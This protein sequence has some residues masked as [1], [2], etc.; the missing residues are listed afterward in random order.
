V[1]CLLKE[2]FLIFLTATIWAMSVYKIS[3]YLKQSSCLQSL[4]GVY[5]ET[6]INSTE[7]NCSVSVHTVIQCD[8]VIIVISNKLCCVSCPTVNRLGL[9]RQ[10]GCAFR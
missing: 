8:S 5:K 9:T 2:W 1:S 4:D 10:T 7:M 3:L 6:E